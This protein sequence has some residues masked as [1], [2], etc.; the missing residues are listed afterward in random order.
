MYAEARV[1]KYCR[2]VLGLKKQRDQLKQYQRRI[3][4][5][6]EKVAGTYNIQTLTVYNMDLKQYTMQHLR[7]VPY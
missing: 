5:V 6:L 7:P 4:G 1:L 2:A 3:Q